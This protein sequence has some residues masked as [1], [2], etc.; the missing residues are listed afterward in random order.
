MTDYICTTCGAVFS[1]PQNDYEVSNGC[2]YCGCDVEKAFPCEHCGDL[3]PDSQA[4]F[5]LCKNCEKEL[6]RAFKLFLAGIETMYGSGGVEYLEERQDGE[7]WKKWR[8][9]K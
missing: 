7:F 5:G 1:M 3:I 6:T 4:K 8:E 2:I 9:W